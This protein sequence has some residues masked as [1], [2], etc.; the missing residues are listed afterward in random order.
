VLGTSIAVAGTK[1]KGV[2]S[3]QSVTSGTWKALPTTLSAPP[4]LTQS[5]VLTFPLS[6]VAPS[7]QYF[8][9]VNTGTLTLTAATY[10]V[11]I[12]GTGGAVATLAA[13]VGGSWNESLGTCSGSITTLVNSTTGSASSTV[14]PTAGNSEIRLRATVSSAVSLADVVTINVSVA[15]SQ[16]RTAKTTSS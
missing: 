13:C 6:V 4:Y 7:P 14:V 3:T 15:R 12:T 9:V 5:L 1:A 2:S 8:W 16:V 11:S 10:S